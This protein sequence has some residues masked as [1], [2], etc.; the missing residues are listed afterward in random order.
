MSNLKVDLGMDAAD[1]REAYVPPAEIEET[2]EDLICEAAHPHTLPQTVVKKLAVL[3]S[4]Q[5]GRESNED[6]DYRAQVLSDVLEHFSPNRWTL[7]NWW[8]IQFSAGLAATDG[9][10]M[11]DICRLIGCSRAA[12]TKAVRKWRLRLKLPRRNAIRRES[13]RLMWRARKEARSSRRAKF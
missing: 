1:A 4:H 11:S 10:T 12:M 7:L 9:K 13:A 3:I 8:A 2:I 6:P 5:V